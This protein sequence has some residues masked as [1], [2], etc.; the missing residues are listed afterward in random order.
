MPSIVS[1]VRERSADEVTT[2]E[3]TWPKEAFDAWWARERGRATFPRISLAS[4]F[5]LPAIVSSACTNDTWSLLGTEV[6]DPR[7]NASAVW[8]GTEMIVWGGDNGGGMNTGGRYNPATDSW[9]PISIGPSAPSPRKYHTAV[10]TGTEM[11]VWGGT[12]GSAYFNSGAR[13]NPATDA[14]I[15]TAI[16]PNTPLPRALH[17]AVWTG[18]Q[19]IVW[20]GSDASSYWNTGGRYNPSTNTWTATS[21]GINVPEERHRMSAVWTGTEMIIWGGGKAFGN[22]EHNDGGRYNPATDSWTPTSVSGDVPSPRMLQSAVW[23]GS[24]MIVWGGYEFA[25]TGGGRYSPATDSWVAMSTENAPSRRFFHAA[26]WTGSEMIIWG[27]SNGSAELNTGARY[28][29]DTDAWVPTSVGTG[30]PAARSSM[31]S[32][33]TGSEMIVWGGSRPSAI[34]GTGARY[35]PSDD[36][37]V[38]TATAASVPAARQ[39]HTAVWTGA[40][41][42]VWGGQGAGRLN[43]GGRYSPSTDTW[44]PTATGLYVPAARDSHSAIWT[45]TEMI[46]WGGEDGTQNFNSG[47]RYNPATDTWIPTSTGTATPLSN[48]RAVWTGR[49]MLVWGG[50]NGL[51]LFTNTG[52]RYSPSFDSWTPT[53]TGTG[54]PFGRTEHTMVWTGTEMIVWGGRTNA[55]GYFNSGGRYNPVSNTW[56]PTSLT[57]VP[58]GRTRHSAVWTGTEMIVWGGLLT[59]G[60]FGNTGGRY[61]PGSNTWIATGVGAGVPASRARHSAVWTGTEMIVWGGETS[62][63]TVTNAG[64]RYDPGIDVW[65]AISTATDA[66]VARRSAATAWTGSEMIVNGGY[67][68]TA[69]GGR[70]CACPGGVLA[71]RDADVDGYGDPGVSLASCDSSI[72][73]GYVL[74]RTDCNDAS[75]SA[76]PGATETCNALDD[77]CDGKIDEDAAGVDSDAEGV[78]NACDNC[79]FLSNPSQSDFDHDGEGD[80]CDLNDG[81]IYEWRDDKTSVSW[82]AEQGPTSWNLYIGDL[83]VLKATG[84]YTQV[85]GSN[86][87]AQRQCGVSTTMVDDPPD[88][89]V[90]KVSFSLVTGVIASVE[91][92]LGSSSAGPRSNQNPC[93]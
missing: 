21:V 29:P 88:P 32:I 48:H 17:V 36:S 35:R 5:V 87:S 43:S 37:W 80:A 27:G 47:G 57:N 73:G 91:G 19:M 33:W 81:L 30:T 72:P 11:I 55:A 45:G 41:V 61:S 59:G 68:L 8:T 54:C 4:N 84:V 26:V 44:T 69:S 67:P 16:D 20:G 3:V 15:A 92:S 63:T 86:P 49:E 14:W 7:S 46:V 34:Y 74:D 90:G 2:A 28:L 64:A 18:S 13:Y 93:P 1:M 58:S 89:D 12:D 25:D 75:P 39:L 78:H 10:W 52:G 70:Y 51:G 56:S 6:P 85:P 77:N 31:S 38:P 65:T 71:Y 62:F 23:T 83:D 79:R 66:P 82:Q 53:S 22:S 9:M 42:I 76:H 50:V 24:E 40:E 60:P